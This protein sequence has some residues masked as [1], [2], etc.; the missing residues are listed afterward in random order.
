VLIGPPGSGKSTF[1][2]RH[3]PATAVIS[4]DACRKLVSDSEDNQAASRQAFD[5]MATII[6]KRMELGRLIVA[7]AMHIHSAFRRRWLGLARRH[8]YPAY[9]IVFAVPAEVCLERDRRRRRKVGREVIRRQAER[10][11][12]KPDD[13]MKEGFQAAWRLGPD[14]LD[15]CQIVIVPGPIPRPRRRISTEPDA[16]EDSSGQSIHGEDG[17]RPVGMSRAA[18]GTC[19]QAQ[20]R[21]DSD[22]RGQAAQ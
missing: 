8:D 12:F 17:P 19:R 1:A 20:A 10:M 7:D 22:S 13:L 5:V 3:F 14:A 6:E 21:C 4:S 11:N 15:E 2:R 18:P 16:C 9:A